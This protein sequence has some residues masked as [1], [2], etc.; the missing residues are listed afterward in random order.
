MSLSSEI[1]AGFLK[2]VELG[3]CLIVLPCLIPSAE[4][5]G[6]SWS[7]GKWVHDLWVKGATSAE[8]KTS[9]F[10]VLT[11]KSDSRLSDD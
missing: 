4:M 2:L 3:K 5:N 10:V 7:L 6:K 8:C 11:V 1:I 9:I